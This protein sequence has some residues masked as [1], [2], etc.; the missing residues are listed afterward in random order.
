MVGRT[1]LTKLCSFSNK[2]PPMT[3]ITYDGLSYSIKFAS[4]QA[5]EKS[6]PDDAVARLRGTEKT[7][8]IGVSVPSIL[9]K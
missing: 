5:L 8:E 1:S 3:K 9:S 6:M 2:P 4:R 7:A